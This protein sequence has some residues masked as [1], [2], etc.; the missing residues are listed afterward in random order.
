MNKTK[1]SL[2]LAVAA[3]ASSVNAATV[4][5]TSGIIPGTFSPAVEPASASGGDPSASPVN[6][7]V[8]SF[9]ST[10]GSL[11]SVTYTLTYYSYAN[12]T[13]NNLSGG[14]SS[15][16]IS[17]ALGLAANSD[18]NTLTEPGAVN[19]TFNGALHAIGTGNILNGNSVG[20][21]NTGSDSDLYNGVVANAN[22]ANYLGNGITD[23]TFVFNPVG[24]SSIGGASNPQG[25]AN[26]QPTVFYAAKI[27]VTYDYTPTGVPEAS[28][29][30]AGAVVL[31]GAG[32]ILRRRMVASKA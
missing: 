16:V 19:K 10:L 28:T 14:T 29:Y 2:I 32:M 11:N 8:D 6:L 18:V 4:F 24:F 31:A 17:W 13:V 1:L 15:Y 12:Y 30:A 22:F 7:L 9:D 23:V 3:A 26:P 21:K 5:E 27:D 20:P 25:Q